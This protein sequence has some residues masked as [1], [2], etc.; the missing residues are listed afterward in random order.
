ML[1]NSF[2]CSFS[3]DYFIFYFSI[4]EAS[5]FSN[6]LRPIPIVKGHLQQ[7]PQLLMLDDSAVEPVTMGLRLIIVNRRSNRDIFT[8]KLSI[9]T[10]FNPYLHVLFMRVPQP[11]AI[12]SLYS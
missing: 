12:I 4:K 1:M 5:L 11:L 9:A 2:S 3:Y 10:R 8:G 7:E 6:H